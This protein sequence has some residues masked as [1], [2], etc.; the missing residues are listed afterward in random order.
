MRLTKLFSIAILFT[1]GISA[2]TLPSGTPDASATLQAIYTAQAATVQVIQTENA[3]T[4]TP[5]AL[6]TFQFPTLPPQTSFP[7]ITALPQNTSTSTPIPVVMRCDHAAFVKDVTVPD[8]T[9]FAP[10]AQFTKT[11]RL[12][13]VGSCTWTTSYALV[14]SSGNSMSGPAAVNL[15]GTVAPGQFVDVSVKL[16]A[17]LADGQHVGYWM[18]RNASGVMFGLGENAQ[19]PFFVNIKVVGDMTTVFDL[20][21]EY[22]HADWRSG[23]GDLGCPG[24]VG[25]KKGYAI[26]VNK[27]QLENGQKYDGKGLLT[28]PERVNNGYLAGYYQPFKVQKGDRFRAIVNCEYQAAGCNVVFRL[29]YQ[30]GNSQIKTFWSFNE[31]YDGLYYTVD[32]DLSPLAGENVTFILNVLANGKA[33]DDK[34]LWI[35][36]RIARPSNLITPSPTPTRTLTVT[37]TM[38]SLPPSATPTA[39]ATIT[40]TLTATVTETILPATATPTVTATPTE[41]GT[42]T[43]TPTP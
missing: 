37:A 15:P 27:P 3:P 14:F 7:T 1:L 40:P 38:T 10:N 6:P 8:G 36:P 22:C 30:I 35:A 41:T 23:A 39:T 13:N 12:Q 31:I 34:P 28:V 4:S 24:N 43:E 29:D 2:C 16:T 19:R 32:L 26:D 17:P 20:A 18:L 21:A 42:P 9:V 5:L 33:D 25:G 11:W